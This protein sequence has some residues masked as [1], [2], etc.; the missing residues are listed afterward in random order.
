MSDLTRYWITFTY[1]PVE[2]EGVVVGLLQPVGFGVTA[3]DLE[4]ALAIVR[5]GFFDRF[6]TYYGLDDMPPVREVVEDVDVSSLD[7][8]VKAH[9]H[10]PNWRGLW[11]PRP[12]PLR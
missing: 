2:S 9:M 5:A 12:E 11:Y 6:E 7:D 10:P 1:P 3:L 8:L 4:D